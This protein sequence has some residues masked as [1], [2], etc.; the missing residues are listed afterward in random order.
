VKVLP[1]LRE[2]ARLW[3]QGRKLKQDGT[4]LVIDSNIF[5]DPQERARLVYLKHC[6]VAIPAAVWGEIRRMSGLLAEYQNLEYQ[7]E[8]DRLNK[9]KAGQFIFRIW[10]KRPHWWITG[11]KRT[12]L[13]T[14]LKNRIL[15]RY[16]AN[17]DLKGRTLEDLV[18][19]NDL[20]IL[21]AC[22]Q[23]ED[24]AREDPRIKKVVLVTKD[25]RLTDIASYMNIIVIATL[26]ELNN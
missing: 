24:E 17:E 8:A 19:I 18:G 14:D 23:L 4:I 5:L 10:K 13:V 16:E 3:F 7:N 15:R 2:R 22:L 25:K 26:N 9:R 12:G 1:N 6:R 11:S 21:A 20:R